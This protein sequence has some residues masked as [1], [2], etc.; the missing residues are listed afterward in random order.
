MT[1]SAHSVPLRRW[2][3]RPPAGRLEPM[4]LACILHN[5]SSI[6]EGS[7]IAIMHRPVGNTTGAVQSMVC[8]SPPGE[9]P[10]NDP[11]ATLR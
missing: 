9:V 6:A 2:G 5:T 7:A 8:I 4:Q 3:S 10:T 11:A 1:L